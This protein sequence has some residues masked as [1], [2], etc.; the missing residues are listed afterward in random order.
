MMTGGF[1]HRVSNRVWKYEKA[2]PLEQNTMHRSTH[3]KGSNLGGAGT[4]GSGF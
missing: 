2:P 3:N 1:L 4:V